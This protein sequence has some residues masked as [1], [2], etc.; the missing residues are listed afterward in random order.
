MQWFLNA[1]IVLHTLY[2][3]NVSQTEC[4]VVSQLG[5]ELV[6]LFGE[7][8]LY[9]LSQAGRPRH[10]KYHLSSPQVSF[11][12]ISWLILVQKL[13]RQVHTNMFAVLSDVHDL[14]HEGHVDGAYA[15]WKST[16]PCKLL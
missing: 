9:P 16:T 8:A 5:F 13:L 10:T 2:V 3:L 7:P 15:S 11:S 4:T 12:T 14:W 6:L 1:H